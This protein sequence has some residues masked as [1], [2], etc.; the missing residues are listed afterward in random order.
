MLVRLSPAEHT[1]WVAAARSAGRG[2]LGAWVRDRVAATLAPVS[3]ATGPT[4]GNAPAADSGVAVSV[5]EWAGLRAELGRVG[6][7]LNQ[8]VRLG[9]GAGVNPARVAELADAAQGT[10]SVV[11]GLLAAVRA[12][13]GAGRVTGSGLMS[14]R[15]LRWTAEVIGVERILYATDYPFIPTGG[16]RAR[17]FVESAALTQAEKTSMASG[18]WEQ[19]TAHL[20]R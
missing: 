10:R 4:A 20:G 6:N 18:G 19:L 2:R 14:P 17:A 5:G 13:T 9:N 8:A 11:A 1:A 3:A 15:Y 12:A 16:G 7:N